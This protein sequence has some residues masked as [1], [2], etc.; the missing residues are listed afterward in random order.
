MNLQCDFVSVTVV[1]SVKIN[2]ILSVNSKACFLIIMFQ[3]HT[4]ICLFFHVCICVLYLEREEEVSQL[5]FCKIGLEVFY[6][7]GN[8]LLCNKIVYCTLSFIVV[9]FYVLIFVILSE[10]LSWLFCASCGACFYYYV[11]CV[12]QL[13]ERRSLAGELTLFCARP[14]ANGWPLCG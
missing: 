5:W 10:D 4:N 1:C 7:R 14:S 2:H 13:A 6:W 12:A 8:L 11:A 9:C 3:Y